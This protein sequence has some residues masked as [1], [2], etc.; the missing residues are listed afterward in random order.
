MMSDID[1]EFLVEKALRSVVKDA[2][3]IAQAQGIPGEHHFYISFKTNHTGTKVSDL[4]KSQYPEEM[5]IVLQHQYQ[6]LCVE[7]DRFSV[8]LQFGGIPQT[9]VIP[10]D[11]VVYFADPS[12]KFGLSFSNAEDL[13]IGEEVKPDVKKVSNEP[14]EVVSIDK[15][16]KKK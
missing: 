13:P 5:T 1:Y 9:L 10:Y 4:L 8:D 14:A 12:T 2:L 6:N 11:A 3:K 7:D 16:R 15:F